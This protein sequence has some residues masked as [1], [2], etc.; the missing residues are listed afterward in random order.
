MQSLEL[1]LQCMTDS[2]LYNCRNATVTVRRISR[3]AEVQKEMVT[4]QN[5]IRAELERRRNE[6]T[7][8]D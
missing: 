3:N 6:D 8:E 2:G 4:I 1:W 5:S 7:A